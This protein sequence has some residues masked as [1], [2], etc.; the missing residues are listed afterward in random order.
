MEMHRDAFFDGGLT[1]QPLRHGKRSAAIR[2]YI[3]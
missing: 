2:L 1:A 3:H